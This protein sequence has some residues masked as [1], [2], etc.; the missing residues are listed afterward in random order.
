MINE[1]IRRVLKRKNQF[2]GCIA[3]KKLF[4]NEI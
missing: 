3:R 1:I 2:N 4:L